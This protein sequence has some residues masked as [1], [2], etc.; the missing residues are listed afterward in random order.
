MASGMGFGALRLDVLCGLEGAQR[1]SRT[2]TVG[3]MRIVGSCSCG[4]GGASQKSTHPRLHIAETQRQPYTDS[5]MLVAT[6]TVYLLEI[7][8]LLGKANPLL[9]VP[10]YE[11]PFCQTRGIGRTNNALQPEP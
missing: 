6:S 9:G 3:D 7:S 8:L 11:L 5:S 4:P 2:S 10:A 1:E